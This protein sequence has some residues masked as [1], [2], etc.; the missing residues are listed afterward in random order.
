MITTKLA[1]TFRGSDKSGNR[2]G[3][4]RFTKV[5]ELS[6]APFPGL[7]IEDPVWDG[8]ETVESVALNTETGDLYVD[9]GRHECEKL[10]DA[11][12]FKSMMEPFALSSDWKGEVDD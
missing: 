4:A 3:E 9:L 5:L 2:I 10:D 1:I 7:E 11:N 6:F 12:A 8:S